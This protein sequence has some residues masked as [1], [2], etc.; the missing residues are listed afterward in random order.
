MAKRSNS[1]NPDAIRLQLEELVGKLQVQLASEDLRERVLS[2]IPV[3]HSV[4]DLGVS[5]LPKDIGSARNRILYYLQQYPGTIIHGEE[6]AVV[7]GIEEYA[8]RIRELRVEFGWQII[9]GITA[10]EAAAEG[11]L[12]GI[13]VKHIQVDDYILFSA[14]QDRDAAFRWRLANSIRKGEGGAKSKILKFFQ[15]NVG[16][17]V[18]LEELRYV[19][20]NASEWARRVR[21]LRTE[22]AW[23]VE[24]VEGG[25]VLQENKQGEV[26]DRNIKQHTYAAVLD[27]D[28]YA[29]RKCGWSHSIAVPGDPRKRLELHHIEHHKAGGKNEADNLITLCNV[30]HDEIHAIGKEWD[31]RDFMEW[32]VK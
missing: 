24:A 31:G 27:R 8:R 17:A 30:H 5:M 23:P 26:H 15:G 9:S 13:E 16:K 2:I 21:E 1:Y 19:A 29:C 32:L 18:S 12:E 14:K 4:R 28:H 6:L 22:D 3:R 7:A 10:R 20:N 25:Y 11:Q